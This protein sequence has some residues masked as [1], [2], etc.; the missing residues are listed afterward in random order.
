MSGSEHGSDPTDATSPGAPVRA[1]RRALI[2]PLDRP[3]LGVA[4]LARATD[5]A[6]GSRAQTWTG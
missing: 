5:D 4:A 1:V 6:V 3:Q 2:V